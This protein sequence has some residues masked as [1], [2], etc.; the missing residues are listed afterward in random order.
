MVF[1]L[2]YWFC[3]RTLHDGI[4]DIDKSSITLNFGNFEEANGSLFYE[5][6]TNV[7]A[8]FMGKTALQVRLT[9]VHDA[10][11]VDIDLLE[12]N[13]DEIQD[14]GTVLAPVKGA[15]RM[16]LWVKREAGD[17][18]MTKIFVVTLIIL[19]AIANVLMGCEV[20]KII[21]SA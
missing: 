19:I 20:L 16:D 11:P 4:A 8:K 3:F 15:S 6:H 13:P 7:D 21:F 9:S 17:T 1:I 2:K 14:F 10:A 12:Y 5:L 18:L